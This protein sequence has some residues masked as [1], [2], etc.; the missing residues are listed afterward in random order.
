MIN[1]L[2]EVIEIY[3]DTPSV[4][5]EVWN[6]FT[7]AVNADGSLR[8]HRDFVEQ[9]GFGYGDRP[10][11]WSW[12]LL[13][14]EMPAQFKF[15]EVGVFQGQILSLIRILS[16]RENKRCEIVGV[17]PLNT[18]GDHAAQHPEMDYR[19][20]IQ[21]IHQ[22]FLCPSPTILKGYSFDPRI[23]NLSREYGPY[24]LMLIDG[25]HDYDVVLDDLNIYSQLVKIGGYLVIDDAANDLDIPTGLIKGDFKGIPD[26][27][28][29]LNEWF[30]GSKYQHVFSVGHNRILKRLA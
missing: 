11:H 14:D 4:H 10:Y 5:R 22:Y 21:F 17:T 26:V 1:S 24:D 9:F 19:A 28:R 2:T 29:A 30:D 23:Q 16:E 3:K 8:K 13:I 27:T 7:G 20:R 12:K 18:E 25:C 6:K 15:L